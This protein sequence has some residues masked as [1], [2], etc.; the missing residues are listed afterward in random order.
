MLKCRLCGNDGKLVKAH[1]IPEAFFR[2]ARRDDKNPR[3]ITDDP[4]R[5]PKRSP[6]GVYDQE[7]LCED[8]EPK[9]A[10]ADDYGVQVLLNRFHELFRP[11][12]YENR[13]VYQAEHINHDLLLRFLV[14]TLW[15]ASVS[16][17][18]F[19]KDISLGHLESLAKQTILNQKRPVPNQFSAILS[20]WVTDEETALATKALLN[21]YPSAVYGV[22]SYR[23]YFGEIV[24]DIKADERP[25]PS[26]LHPVMLLHPTVILVDRELRSSKDFVAMV[27]TAEQSRKN[28]ETSR[29]TRQ[30][31]AK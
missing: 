30:K 19:Y 27:H 5:F 24:A 9:F 18:T 14:A 12:M 15:R 1:V 23:F 17:H 28:Y 22:N 6:I 4:N 26:V 8:C 21:P 2:R 3:L 10:Q 16:T 13:I 25:L 31:K 7:I 20:R 11:V 29:S